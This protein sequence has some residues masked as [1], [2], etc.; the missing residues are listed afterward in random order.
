MA[1]DLKTEARRALALCVINRFARPFDDAA[2]T[3]MKQA[4]ITAHSF[5][6]L[7]QED[8]IALISRNGLVGA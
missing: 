1:R 7:S 6:V 4:V 8:A 3:K 2:K 5:D